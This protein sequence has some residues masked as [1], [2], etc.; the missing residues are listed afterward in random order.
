MYHKNLKSVKIR[1]RSPE[2]KNY[3]KTGHKPHV[4]GINTGAGQFS[5]DILVW[6]PL[7]PTGQDSIPAQYSQLKKQVATIRSELDGCNP[8]I[9]KLFPKKKNAKPDAL[10]DDLRKR[11]V[12]ADLVFAL[13]AGDRPLLGHLIN[14]RTEMP[15]K[16][17]L[18]I[19]SKT[20]TD[21]IERII[22]HAKSKKIPDLEKNFR[23]NH[24]FG[25]SHMLDP[26]VP[27]AVGCV[28]LLKWLREKEEEHGEGLKEIYGQYEHEVDV[29]MNTGH[30]AFLSLLRYLRG[31]TP[32]ELKRHT[33]ISQN[34]IESLLDHF[35]KIGYVAKEAE[36]HTLTDAA[37][38]FFDL[39]EFTAPTL[40][41]EKKINIE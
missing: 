3:L 5:A 4:N 41:Q 10:I 29:F 27:N 22:R 16:L 14:L 37:D 24:I 40:E 19:D 15:D 30:A 28:Q 12:K 6:A 9:R 36:N 23:N 21:F 13:V 11:C 31:A 25:F 20:K 1:G 38:F 34:D 18:F 32:D 33:Y 17:I 8:N 35:L 39:F 7:D 26:K 2:A